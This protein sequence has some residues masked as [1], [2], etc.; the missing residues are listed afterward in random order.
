[1]VREYFRV[2]TRV[3]QTITSFFALGTPRLGRRRLATGYPLAGVG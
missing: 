2:D 3:L 1:M